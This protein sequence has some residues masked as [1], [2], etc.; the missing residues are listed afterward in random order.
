MSGLEALGAISSCIAIVEASIK[1][2]QF[3]K[4]VAK[5]DSDRDEFITR[6]ERV[7]EIAERVES[8]VRS[9]KDDLGRQRF[10]ALDPKN[11]QSPLQKLRTLLQD[12]QKILV[13]G[14]GTN[15]ASGK[16]HKIRLK[17]FKWPGEKKSLEDLR[18]TLD[19]YTSEIEVFMIDAVYDISDDTNIVLKTQEFEAE[20][21]S[22]IRWLS[23]LDFSARQQHWYETFGK[24]GTGDRFLKSEPFKYWKEK[25]VKYLRC[26]GD[27]GAGKVR[28]LKSKTFRS[29]CGIVAY[30]RRL[31]SLVLW[32]K[33]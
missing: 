9:Q 21:R 4:D 29:S 26:Y 5:A 19:G 18:K 14:R 10:A 3:L 6:L 17:D 31:S 8:R 22:I 27:A 23:P 15:I 7:V 32:L 11:S 33:N 25:K 13:K 12:M 16:I 24:I 2:T 28:I 20:R 1:V 30:S